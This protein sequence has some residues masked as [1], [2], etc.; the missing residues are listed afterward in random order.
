MQGAN[1][2]IRGEFNHS[3]S[4]IQRNNGNNL[5][6]GC[7]AQGHIDTWTGGSNRQSSNLRTT[8]LPPEPQ[9]PTTGCIADVYLSV[10]WRCQSSSLRRQSESFLVIKCLS[11]PVASGE[12]WQVTGGRSLGPSV[13]S[14]WARCCQPIKSLLG[15]LSLTAPQYICLF[16]FIHSTSLFHI[17]TPHLRTHM[18]SPLI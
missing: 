12:M 4:F 18:H 17:H 8:A 1:L 2:L 9:P 3:F 11:I 10:V 15:R 5:G 16:V 14:T 6:L 13:G 7:L